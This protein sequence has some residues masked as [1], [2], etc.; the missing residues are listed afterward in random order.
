[1]ESWLLGTKLA[2][3]GYV[4][5]RWGE[6]GSVNGVPAVLLVLAFVSVTVLRHIA[7]GSMWTLVWAVLALAIAAASSLLF[8]PLFVLLIPVAGAEV[9]RLAF[10]HDRF[11]PVPALIPF[12]FVH[13]P[14]LNDYLLAA[15]FGLFIYYLA[16]RSE[17][18]LDALLRDNDLLRA[19][20]EAQR[21]RAV[22]GAEYEVEL[23]RLAQLEER[24]RLAIEVHDR[25]GHAI[26]GSVV[27]LEAAS[28]LLRS[29]PDRAD[30]MVSQS[31]EVLREG[32]EGIRALL[33]GMKPESEE[34]GIQRL[35]ALLDR[36]SAS[37]PIESKLSHSG[38]LAILAPAQW[39]AIL[40]N[41]REALTNVLKH[42]AA[43]VVRTTID[44]MPKLT[45]VEI[46]DN[47]RGA[48]VL[49][50]GLGIRGIEE[51]TREAGGTLIVD[52]TK[53][54]SVIMLFPHPGERSG[55]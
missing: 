41:A 20:N 3:V 46:H 8:D 47:G 5:V 10:G 42:S 7:K 27:Q 38:D 9:L 37:S 14:L 11:A 30:R 44:V 12:L 49:N 24:N 22:A 39:A 55:D 48:F 53:G 43:T 50:K 45:K 2:V 1:M 15:L 33:Q 40:D 18:R 13:A 54:F 31:A 32:M 17:R 21:V 52:G 16:T 51:R 26:A 23:R 4:A 34:L 28:V 19:A 25:V 36:F 6:T 35:R 29:D